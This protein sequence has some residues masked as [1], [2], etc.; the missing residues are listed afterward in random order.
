MLTAFMAMVSSNAIAQE[1]TWT[2]AD[3]W[4]A[5]NSFF[6][7]LMDKSRNIYKAD[8]KQP[9]ASH[10][11]NGFRDGDV[12]GCAAA[13]WCQAPYFDMAINAQKLAQK[14]TT[15]SDNLKKFYKSWMTNI[16]NGEKNHYAGFNFHD[17]NTN[18]GWFIYDDIMWWT[19]ALARA[20]QYDPTNADYLKYAEES[21]CRVWYG[22]PVVGDTGSYSDPLITGQTGG[23]YWQW[24]PLVN[25]N[26]NKEGDYKS[27]CIN[28]PAVCAMATLYQVVPENRVAPTDKY[29]TYQ[30][31]EFYLEKAK[32]IY[33]WAKAKLVP[34]SG[35]VADGMH[36]KGPEYSNHL[37]NQATYIGASCL[38]Y[39][40]TGD[41]QYLS[42]ARLAVYYTKNY[43]CV[44]NADGISVLPYENGYEQGIYCAI[45]AQYMDMFINDL[46]QGDYQ[47]CKLWLRQNIQLGWNNRDS[48]NLNNGKFNEKTAEAS[49]VESY[50]GSALPSL[51]LL[52]P[53]KDNVV[54]GI[55]Q[56]TTEKASKDNTI[57]SIE[58][59][60][61]RT[62]ADIEDIDTLDKG[63][64]IL[65]GEKYAVR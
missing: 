34:T 29:P 43:M 8:T 16:Y 6:N 37:Y 56:L 15:L 47:N 33:A 38:L 28:F 7:N 30:T 32:E 23:M 3:V 11:G 9:N 48:R 42:N 1:F 63:L 13:I 17:G 49:C 64:Y 53:A 18:T 31:K 62:N 58:G 65:N 4:T 35:R 59:K 46:G 55:S 36:G 60:A 39:K 10:R 26:P 14:S 45:F 50:G 44:K 2:E 41:S 57:Y 25:P 61:L 54:D 19:G 24:Q 5:Y 52:F 22:S 40:I 12:S 27:A 20:Y 21:F 51:M